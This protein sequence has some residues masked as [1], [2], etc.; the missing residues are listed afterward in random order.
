MSA[1]CTNCGNKLGEGVKFCTNCG[2]PVRV[3]AVHKEFKTYYGRRI[4]YSIY[5]NVRLVS[6]ESQHKVHIAVTII[7][8]IITLYED[9]N[10]LLSSRIRCALMQR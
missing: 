2:K 4:D 10:K 6:K 1:Y 3:D 8:L 7:D 5:N 9:R